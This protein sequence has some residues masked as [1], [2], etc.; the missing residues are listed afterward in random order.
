M[1]KLFFFQNFNTP[2]P[3]FTHPSLYML[4]YL[5]SELMG[6][7]NVVGDRNLGQ[8]TGVAL[9]PVLL[10]GPWGDDRSNPE[11]RGRLIL[12]SWRFGSS[13]GTSICPTD[14]VL[15][16]ISFLLTLLCLPFFPPASS[17]RRDMTWNNKLKRDTGRNWG[18][19]MLLNK[20]SRCRR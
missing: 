14:W 6:N 18:Q 15:A 10:I 3:A 8:W 1:S 19:Y 2:K 11:K 4:V 12:S 9:R 7:I 13:D 16:L 5:L 20:H 17:D